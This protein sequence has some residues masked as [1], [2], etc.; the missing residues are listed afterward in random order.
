M[1]L[2]NYKVRLKMIWHI[3]KDRQVVIISTNKGNGY[4]NWILVLA[5]EKDGF[6]WLP[7]VAEYRMCASYDDSEEKQ[8]W[9][10]YTGGKR[11]DDFANILFF[12]E[13]PI[14][15]QNYIDEYI[16]EIKKNLN[17]EIDRDIFLENII[18]NAKN[19]QL[20]YYF[21]VTRI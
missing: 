10:S 12:R 11:I 21:S 1:N 2:I 13:L 8:G 9:Y 19:I 14:E 17:K 16:K 20:K 5:I 15:S 7:I 3:I 18:E 6:Q 4:Y